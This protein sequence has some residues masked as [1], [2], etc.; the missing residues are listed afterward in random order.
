[1]KKRIISIMLA[2]CMV[3]SLVPITAVAAGGAPSLSSFATK[4]QLMTEYMTDSDGK[5]T[6]IGKLIFGKNNEN[7]PQEWYILGE[8]TGVSGDNVAVFTSKYI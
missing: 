6:N 1:M 2:I 7:E 8:D 5:A 4:D 3:L